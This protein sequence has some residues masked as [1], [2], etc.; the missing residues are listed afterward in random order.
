MGLSIRISLIFLCFS[1]ISCSALALPP[2][3]KAPNFELTTSKGETVS[4]ERYQ[5]QKPVL[6]VFWT[7][8]CPYCRQELKQMEDFLAGF[9][10]EALAVLGINSGWRDTVSRMKQFQEKYQLDIPLAF[11][12]Q[13]LVSRDYSIRGVP[14]ILVV[15]KQGT[16]AFS[17]HRFSDRLAKALEAVTGSETEQ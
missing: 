2:G 13:H 15:D 14:T 7:T 11:D 3:T 8:W 12:H 4:L 5:G 1:C 6:L 10:E 9:Q 17:G 16:V